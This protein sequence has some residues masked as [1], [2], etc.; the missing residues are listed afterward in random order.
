MM[1]PAAAPI[2]PMPRSRERSLLR[3][4]RGTNFRGASGLASPIPVPLIRPTPSPSRAPS[5]GLP[6]RLNISKPS[7]AQTT[8]PIDNPEHTNT[9]RGSPRWSCHHA[10]WRPDSRA[11]A[12][13][14]RSA[15]SGS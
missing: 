13:S 7:V 3:S 6:N 5:K 9:P 2:S 12:A 14:H 10:I 4:G 15:L 11:S 8:A 1:P